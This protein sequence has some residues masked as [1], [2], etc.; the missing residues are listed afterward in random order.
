MHFLVNISYSKPEFK[1]LSCHYQFMVSH[2]FQFDR[3]LIHGRKLKMFECMVAESGM[4]FIQNVMIL[5][6]LFQQ[7][8]TDTTVLFWRSGDRASWYV[9][10]I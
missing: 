5:H 3:S 7:S 9:L 8:P 6:H 4:I 2:G 1:W 10:I